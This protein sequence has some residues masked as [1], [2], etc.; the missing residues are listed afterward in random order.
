MVY[1]SPLCAGGHTAL[2]VIFV[3]YVEFVSKNPADSY[4]GLNFVS[5][6]AYSNAFRVSS[7][8]FF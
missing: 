2:Q 5:L 3:I 4:Y 1:N 6:I 8:T 7:L